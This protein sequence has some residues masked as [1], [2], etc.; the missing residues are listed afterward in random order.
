[1]TSTF[2]TSTADG[3]G[4]G[5]VRRA[6]PWRR[7]LGLATAALAL[8]LVMLL[9]GWIPNRVGN[10]G[11]LVDTFLPWS[12][13]VLPVLAVGALVRRSAS[14]TVA[15]LLPVL[16][17]LGLF[18]GRLGDRTGP[19]GDLT[20]AEH[21]VAAA[22]ADPAGTARALIASGADVLA[23]VEVP[24]RAL[25]T[26]EQV[27]AAAYPYHAVHNTVGLWSRLPLS[28]VRPIDLRTDVGPAGDAK[29][30]DVKLASSRALH[31]TV[32]TPGGPLAVYVA[33][34]ASTRLT[35][36]GFATDQ[37]DRGVEAL[38]DAVAADPDPRVL[39]LGDLNGSLD[40][41]AF[42][43]LGDRARLRSAQDDAGAGFGLS[44]PAAFPVLRIDQIL[45]RS[46]TARSAWVLPA[47][48][49]DH[50]PLA[51]RFSI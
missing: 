15:L 29:P 46:L 47:T 6:E 8:G 7:G 39:L 23:L 31:A 10:L 14:A 44:W 50:L 38:A 17:W 33:H 19:G 37:R 13:L 2:R 24:E 20:V 30:L 21:N 45:A 49:S 16:V 4:I 18:G 25:S 36:R 27:L 34:L 35:P 12:G 32:T 41:R 9:H 26:Y 3:E 43:A 28:D 22:N 11:S 51:A 1:M 40:D 5:G 48:G 42:A